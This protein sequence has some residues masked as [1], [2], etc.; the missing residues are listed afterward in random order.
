MHFVLV[1]LVFCAVAPGGEG[2]ANY[3]LRY[4]LI[5]LIL[6]PFKAFYEVFTRQE[7]YCEIGGGAH[8]PRTLRLKDVSL[9]YLLALFSGINC[10]LSLN[11]TGL[12]ILT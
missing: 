2:N 9:W 6:S 8:L 5:C 11:I 3:V 10:K 12:I 4:I 1:F 7:G